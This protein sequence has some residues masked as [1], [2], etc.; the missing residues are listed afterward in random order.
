M[1]KKIVI[2]M[3]LIALTSAEVSWANQSDGVWQS[4]NPKPTDQAPVSNN[5]TQCGDKG[6]H[7]WCRSG[8][9][10]KSLAEARS[11]QKVPEAGSGR[12]YAGIKGK[13][14]KYSS[15]K[16]YGEKHNVNKK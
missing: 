16:P 15:L 1:R 3:A 9:D 7:S 11:A 10:E 4:S 8:K 12:R 2:A 5:P 13:D 6:T 14:I